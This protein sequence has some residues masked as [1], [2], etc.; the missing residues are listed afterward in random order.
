MPHSPETLQEH[1][2]GSRYSTESQANIAA[3]VSEEAAEESSELEISEDEYI[4]SDDELLNTVLSS[5]EQRHHFSYTTS[6][7]DHAEYFSKT[8]SHAMESVQLDKSLAA[9]AQLSGQ[10]NNKNQKLLEKQAELAKKLSDLKGL[11]EY[12]LASNRIGDL[13]KDI[14]GIS[15]R[16]E[17]LKKGSQKSL[18][19]GSRPQ[20]GVAGR[21]P[22]EYNQARDKVLERS[23]NDL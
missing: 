4:T 6:L 22:V 21:Y 19:F 23:E 10:I 17:A 12:H 13:E 15:V 8:L 1:S 3:V 14:R 5:D 7:S 9:Q 16:I 18:L 11:Y 20:I 2:N